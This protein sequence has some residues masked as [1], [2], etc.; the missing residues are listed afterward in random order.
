MTS[1]G[2][3][4]TSRVGRCRGL[5]R[6][7]PVG[8]PT[9]LRR[10]G[11]AYWSGGLRRSHAV[12]ARAG[13]RAAGPVVVVGAKT[14]HRAHAHRARARRVRERRRRG[15]R[16]GRG[17]AGERGHHVRGDFAEDVPL[18]HGV[19]AEAGDRGGLGRLPPAGRA[20]QADLEAAQAAGA[21][22][23]EDGRRAPVAHLALAPLLGVALGHKGRLGGRA[24]RLG[25]DDDDGLAAAVASLLCHDARERRRQVAQDVSRVPRLRLQRR[26][27]RR[28][29]LA[30]RRR[31][32]LLGRGQPVAAAVLEGAE[33]A[34][35]ARLPRRCPLPRG[36]PAHE[37]EA[38]LLGAVHGARAAAAERL[39]ARRA[40]AVRLNLELLPRLERG[41]VRRRLLLE[42]DVAARAALGDAPLLGRGQLPPLARAPQRAVLGRV[43]VLG[44]Q[45]PEPSPR[46]RLAA[47]RTDGA[48]RERAHLA[49]HEWPL[50]HELVL[51]EPAGRRRPHV[52]NAVASCAQ[53]S[54]GQRDGV[55][56]GSPHRRVLLSG[57]ADLRRNHKAVVHGLQHHLRRRCGIVDVP[58]HERVALHAR[59]LLVTAFGEPTTQVEPG[60]QVAERPQWGGRAVA[61][62]YAELAQP[63][64]RRSST[65]RADA[66]LELLLLLHRRLLRLW[67]RLEGIQCRLDLHHRAGGRG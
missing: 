53:H 24:A 40:A 32:V 35:D 48:H 20:L 31:G 36:Q 65:R 8:P 47:G 14:R 52:R 26:R 38:A 22:A 2:A 7:R 10:R 13:T 51:G 18:C 55:D 45:L 66:L 27:R 63:Q 11:Y 46:R 59:R 33:V 49:T 30:V 28:L 19:R 41:P 23:R 60:L 50:A 37:A 34:H 29:R 9:Y 42:H 56:E 57:G 39:V 17:A 58:A 16:A 67:V 1:R 43:G 54:A 44:V 21:I 61:V 62:E 6:S 25:V 3:R 12:L 5:G 64:R 4:D 15:E